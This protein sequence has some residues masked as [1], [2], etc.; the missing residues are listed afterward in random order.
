[1]L[2]G[3]HL[4]WPRLTVYWTPSFFAYL[5]ANHITCLNPKFQGTHWFIGAFFPFSLQYH[6]R[7][8]QISIISDFPDFTSKSPKWHLFNFWNL[9]F[10]T[11]LTCP[12]SHH[13]TVPLFHSIICLVFFRHFLSQISCQVEMVKSSSHSL[14]L[15][16]NWECTL[17]TSFQ[18]E[19]APSHLPFFF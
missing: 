4:M 12:V 15:G 18:M 19:C 5:L 10:G 2:S 3:V 14:D 1:M 7:K 17:S 11:S 8:S 13:Q 16:F 6:F 9:N